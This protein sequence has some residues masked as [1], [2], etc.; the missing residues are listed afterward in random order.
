M[1]NRV[2][3]TIETTNAAFGLSGR[4]EVARLLRVAADRIE[5]EPDSVLFHLRDV[6]GNTCGSVDLTEFEEMVD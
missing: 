3:V 6:N 4:A 5:D 2:N 1:N